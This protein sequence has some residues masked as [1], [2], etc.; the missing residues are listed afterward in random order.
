MPSDCEV[1]VIAYVS[2]AAAHAHE[3]RA[4]ETHL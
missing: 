2:S 1:I 4:Y 3:T